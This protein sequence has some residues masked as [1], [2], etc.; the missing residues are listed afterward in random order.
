MKTHKAEEYNA[1]VKALPKATEFEVVAKEKDGEHYV[2]GE[3]YKAIIVN[4]KIV[5][6]PSK[7]YKLVQHTDAFRPII[8]GLTQSGAKDWQF[9]LKNNASQAFLQVFTTA[10]TDGKSQILLGFQVTNSFDRTTTVGYNLSTK[11][12]RSWIEMV[13]YRQVCSN[14][15]KIRVP[16]H[17]AEFVKPEVR[18]EIEKLLE[19]G[20]SFKHTQNVTEKIVGMQYI[21]EAMS[22][23]RKPL[24]V[25]ISKAQKIKVVDL[26]NCDE[27]IKKHF[28]KRLAKTI[29]SRFE[30]D[31]HFEGSSLWALYN[32]ITYEA[33]HGDITV[34][35]QERMLNNASAFLQ[36]AMVEAS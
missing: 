7:R 25:M 33:S 16:L 3:N 4:D 11:Q 9:N 27:L 26:E 31:Q 10:I 35:K 13:G 29:N 32:A 17:E 14:G 28:G 24:Q 12:G 20:F 34:A 1:Y 8:E 15:M 36:E 6:I 30:D 18:T 22:L 5:D 2:N 23:L 21:V 19:Y